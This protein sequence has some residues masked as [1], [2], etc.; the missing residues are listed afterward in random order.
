MDLPASEIA[1]NRKFPRRGF[2]RG[3]GCLC[4]GK[5]TVGHGVQIGEGGLSFSLGQQFA[6]QK[7][8]VLSFQVPGGSF[9][10][11]RAEMSDLKKGE[12][13]GQFIL[14]CLFKNLKFEHKREIRA[15]VSARSE[16]EE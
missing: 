9:I 7:E 10:S 11:V 2:N 14:I 1:R 13:P 4:D 12:K 5:Y 15:Y 3:L 16:F 6:N 8:V